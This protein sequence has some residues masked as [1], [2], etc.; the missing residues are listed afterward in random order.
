MRIDEVIV[1]AGL[2]E[3]L[4]AL[5]RNP[6]AVLCAGGTEI[7]SGTSA[8]RTEK[9]RTLVSLHS[10][11]EL[12]HVSRTDHY[13]EVGS[14]TT[15][16]EL[17]NLKEG[18][19][20][21]TLRGV[22]RGIGTFAVRNLATLG[23]NLSVADRFRDCFPVLACMDAL[24][25]YRQGTLARWVNLNRLIGAGGTPELP[26]GELLTRIRI[27]LGEW[28]LGIAHKLG[29]PRINSRD[30]SQFVVLARVEKRVL[31][32]VRIMYSFGR[33]LRNREIEAALGGKK[34]PLPSRDMET[35]IGSYGSYCAQ[36]GIPESTTARFLALV[37]RAFSQLNEGSSP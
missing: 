9:P 24:A 30:S 18:F 5:K 21:E 10:L 37:R 16:S 12:R 7:F 25:E 29:F 27:P 28:D 26:G 6:G 22:V 4:T 31:S 36:T 3:A 33:A 35:A 32:D 1:P 23:G 19:L 11:P 34:I 13:V 14:M 17:L 15:L 2:G 20:P 8:D